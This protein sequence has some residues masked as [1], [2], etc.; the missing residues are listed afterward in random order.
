MKQTKSVGYSNRSESVPRR[1]PSQQMSIEHLVERIKCLQSSLN[2]FIQK[3]EG[4]HRKA[5]NDRDLSPSAGRENFIESKRTEQ[6]A[7]AF[8]DSVKATEMFL[9]KSAAAVRYTLPAGE[10]AEVCSPIPSVMNTNGVTRL[11]RPTLKA[12]FLRFGASFHD[13]APTVTGRPALVDP[14][15]SDS[16]VSCLTNPN[17]TDR[18]VDRHGRIPVGYYPRADDTYHPYASTES[19][20]QSSALS[21]ES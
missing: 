7:G 21:L 10:V 3:L 6:L 15:T 5:L 4:C 19:S 13:K 18:H 11:L 2:V 14:D 8:V 12:R 16:D 1:G 9:N 17:S 20:R